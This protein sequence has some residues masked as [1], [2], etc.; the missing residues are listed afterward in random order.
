MLFTDQLNRTIRLENFPPKRMVSLVPSQ[1][2]LLYD[3]GLENEVVGITKFCI[4]PNSWFKTKQRVGGTKSVKLDVIDALKPELIIANKEENEQQQMEALCEKYPVY[5]SNIFNLEDALK[6]IKDVGEI[7]NTSSKSNEL[8]KKIHDEFSNLKPLT[9]TKTCA[10]L[11]WKNP[12]M[13]CGT[14]TFVNDMLKRVGL[15]NV[16]D[17]RYPEFGIDELKQKNPEVVLLSSE[18][19]PFKENH[20]QE[21][22]KNLSNS[23]ILLVD[24]EL[25]SWYGSRLLQAPNYFSKLK[26]LLE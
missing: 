11:I 7:T 25:F 9:T 19:Y 20:I 8:I 3:L 17:G 23:T 4:H 6:M 14:E 16:F 21:L 18:P 15:K 26:N 2:E 1:T 22:K 12:Y 5:V 24:G 10:Y 13:A